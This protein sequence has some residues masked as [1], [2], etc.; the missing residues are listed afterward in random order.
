LTEIEES[1]EEKRKGLKD[2]RDK[3]VLTRSK[4][5]KETMKGLEKRL[6]K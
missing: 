2:L 1:L 5:Y 6:E 3:D 4:K